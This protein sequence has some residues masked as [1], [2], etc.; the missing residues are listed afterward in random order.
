M[1]QASMTS[2]QPPHRKIRLHGIGREELSGELHHGTA[3]KEIDLLS[4]L[5]GVWIHR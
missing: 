5:I 3:K 2:P 1:S 4:N